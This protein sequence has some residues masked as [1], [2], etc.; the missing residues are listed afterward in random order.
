[1]SNVA[2]KSEAAEI[3]AAASEAASAL[4]RLRWAR[5]TAQERSAVAAMLNKARLKGRKRTG[6]EPAQSRRRK[7]SK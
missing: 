3:E 7:S 2:A 4:V 5:T 1:M 6:T